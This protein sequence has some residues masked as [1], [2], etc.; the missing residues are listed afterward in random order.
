VGQISKSGVSRHA[1]QQLHY[2]AGPPERQAGMNVLAKETQIIIVKALLEGTSIRS[3]DRMTGVH[4]DTIM[5][6]E[7]LAGTS[8]ANLLDQKVLDIEPK[9]LQLDEIWT[10]VFKKQA[11]I[12]DEDHPSLGDQYVWVALDPETKLVVTHYVGKRDA[13][14]AF[15]FNADLKERI[16]GFFSLLKRGVVGTSHHVSKQHLHRYLSE[17]DFRY[18]AR[19]VCDADRSLM[20]LRQIGGKRL[21]YRDSISAKS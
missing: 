21:R 3:I 2:P 12:S 13:A 7:L 20:V 5:R 8:C 6:L 1:V 10:F 11:R 16:E 19:H 15:Y 18:N 14:S 4:R 9:R 17:F